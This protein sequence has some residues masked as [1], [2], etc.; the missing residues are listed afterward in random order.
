MASRVSLAVNPEANKNEAFE[1]R[2]IGLV[3]SVH[4]RLRT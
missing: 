3:T 4:D 1:D 2:S